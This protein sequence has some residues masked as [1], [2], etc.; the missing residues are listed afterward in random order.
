MNTIKKIWNKEIVMSQGENWRETQPL[1]NF[2]QVGILFILSVGLFVCAWQFPILR[3]V[4]ITVGAVTSI[5]AVVFF[6]ALFTS[7]SG[8]YKRK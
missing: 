8:N 3:G 1:S 2:L 5:F 7:M 4:F 6:K